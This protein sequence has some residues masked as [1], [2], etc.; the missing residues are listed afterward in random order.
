[1]YIGK[2]KT[3]QNKPNVYTIDKNLGVLNL[4]LILKYY[5]VV[6]SIS[7]ITSTEALISMLVMKADRVSS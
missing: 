7:V 3:K 6:S 1:M 5:E 2:T 4:I